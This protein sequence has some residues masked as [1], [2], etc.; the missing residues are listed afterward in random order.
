M[1]S[2]YVAYDEVLTRQIALKV[3][4]CPPSKDDDLY[5][6]AV[7]EA[8]IV[9]GLNHENIAQ[10]YSMGEDMG[11]PFIT[12]ELVD[13]GSGMDVIKAVGRVDPEMVIDFA[14]GTCR[15]LDYAY[16]LGYLHRDIKPG[17]V[18]ITRTGTAKIIDWGLAARESQQKEG[19][20][21]GSPYYM[22][23]EI[24]RGKVADFR[25]DIYSVGVSMYHMLAGEPPF[26]ASSPKEV[27]LKRFKESAPDL[28]EAFDIHPFLSRLVAWT[29]NI[30][31]EDRPESYPELIAQLEMAREKIT[32]KSPRRNE[33]ERN[34]RN[35]RERNERNSRRRR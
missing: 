9:A 14:L 7:Q 31:P 24:A 15:G 21:M 6:G 20:V 4:A 16:R 3:I 10:I 11:Q 34:D 28:D 2:V 27:I 35:T 32:E 25:A 23:P 12:M 1:G 22:A 13:G 30:D 18:L 33:R 5:Q 29:M 26:R 17:N 19:K 8:R